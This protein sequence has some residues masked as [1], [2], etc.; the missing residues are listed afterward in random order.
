MLKKFAVLV[1]LLTAM[2]G[3]TAC[4]S[5]DDKP[6]HETHEAPN[7]D[8]FND[9]DAEFASGMIQHH[10]QALQMVDLTMGRTLDPEVQALAEDIRMTQAPE[11]DQ[12]TTWL[13]DWG[14]PV[15]ETVRDHANAHADGDMETDPDMPGMMPAEDI[16][17]LEAAQGT[18]FQRRWLEMMVD[19]H[20]GAVEMARSEQSDGTNEAAIELA[21]LIEKS[22]QGEIET[23]ESLLE[24]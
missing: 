10:A 8:E 17:E 22:Q 20:E 13:T 11:I 1:A 14:R 18:D 9:A 15:P 6:E 5:E 7:G 3:I 4:G 21:E 19:H 2:S 23:M 24:S 12:M 16:A